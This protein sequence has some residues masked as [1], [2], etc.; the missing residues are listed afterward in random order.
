LR[1]KTTPIGHTPALISLKEIEEV[2][3]PLCGA[4]VTVDVRQGP[5]GN[6]RVEDF[7]ETLKP[8][9]IFAGDGAATHRCGAE[10]RQREALRLRRFTEHSEAGAD[11]V[12]H[13]VT[14]KS[15][16]ATQ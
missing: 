4:L 2:N 9:T 5:A 16:A 7:P 11:G 14:E 1:E 3:C 13:D 10:D 12:P 8:A 15:C 6:R